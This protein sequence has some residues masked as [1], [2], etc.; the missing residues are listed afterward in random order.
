M[1]CSKTN[2]TC[3]GFRTK[4]FCR[5]LQR[6]AAL[7]LLLESLGP[8]ILSSDF[9]GDTDHVSTRVALI[10]FQFAVVALGEGNIF[11]EKLRRASKKTKM[12]FLPDVS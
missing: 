4:T 1:L 10:G 12:Y 3:N 6:G 2:S 5:N 7:V 8:V 9:R 11:R